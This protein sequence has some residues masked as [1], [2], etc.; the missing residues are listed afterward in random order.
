[1]TQLLCLLILSIICGFITF[2]TKDIFN[3]VNIVFL[4]IFF[5]LIIATFRFSSLQNDYWVT[6]TIFI[7]IQAFVILFIFPVILLLIKAPPKKKINYDVLKYVGIIRIISLIVLGIGLIENFIISGSF[8]PFLNATASLHKDSVPGLDF[9]TSTASGIIGIFL[10]VYYFKE[11]NKFDLL[12]S[13]LLISL[14]L[15]KL[16]RIDFI[17]TA[18]LV[19]VLFTY[20]VKFNLKKILM[21]VGGV[22]SLLF[23]LVFIANYRSTAGYS[24]NIDYSESIMYTGPNDPFNLIAYYY[25]YFPLSFE[26]FDL[27]V[28][29][30]T[31]MGDSFLTYGLYTL[32][33]IT[34]GI[35]QL[36]NI[37]ESYPQ[38]DYFASLTNPAYKAEVIATLFG[39]YYVDFGSLFIALP[40]LLTI[41]PFLYLYYKKQD[42]LFKNLLY[43]L[44]ASSILMGGWSNFIISPLILQKIIL[45]MIFLKLFS[46]KFVIKKNTGDIKV[47]YD[48]ISREKSRSEKNEY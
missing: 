1:M 37:I 2:R 38:T 20:L 45:L 21:L 39:Y 28:R 30:T 46:V 7:F 26:N 24:Y 15:L 44:L 25:G 3:P 8:L 33:P 41:I 34:L 43:A 36:N 11:K 10:V 6:D 47:S 22:F 18:L 23:S 16:S 48:E 5:H 9:F 13:F 42:D 14:P 12:L 40:L 31:N 35:F 27:L 29:N 19:I 4:G 17:L 32:R